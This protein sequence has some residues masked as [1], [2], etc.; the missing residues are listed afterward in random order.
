[1]EQRDP[2][3]PFVQFSETTAK[4]TGLGTPAG[5]ED[6]VELDSKMT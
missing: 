6:P 4:V 1:M 2:H 3:C 5:K